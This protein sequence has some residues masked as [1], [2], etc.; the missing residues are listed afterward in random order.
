[1]KHIK[2]TLLFILCAQLLTACASN[3]DAPTESSTSGVDPN[4]NK[5][6]N[7]PWNKPQPWEGSG[8]LGGAM[9]H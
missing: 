8:Q 4:G 2:T 9:G 7:V 6:S 1:M 3:S 5:V